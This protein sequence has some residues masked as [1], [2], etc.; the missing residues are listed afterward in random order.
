MDHSKDDKAANEAAAQKHN[1]V[2]ERLCDNLT[3]I[4]RNGSMDFAAEGFSDE[5]ARF[6]CLLT[7]KIVVE[8]LWEQF[9]IEHSR[10]EWYREYLRVNSEAS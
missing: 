4:I 6:D 2:R 5:I 9:N 1:K 10:K 7:I 8:D 3:A